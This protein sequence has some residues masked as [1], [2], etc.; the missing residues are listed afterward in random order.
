MTCP[1]F[2]TV[3]EHCRELWRWHLTSAAQTSEFSEMLTLPR[4][5][6]GL[7]QR[8]QPARRTFGTRPRLPLSDF[9]SHMRPAQ[10][11]RPAMR[12]DLATDPAEGRPV[13]DLRTR[14]ETKIK[15][16]GFV[17]KTPGETILV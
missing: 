17:E 10:L 8:W 11:T 7:V 2:E 4:S 9:D 12:P 15:A 13:H 3:N 16:S 1:P 6:G 5:A 14:E